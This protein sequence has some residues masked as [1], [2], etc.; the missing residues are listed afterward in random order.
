MHQLQGM[1]QMSL[2]S[3]I[4]DTKPATMAYVHHIAGGNELQR[5]EL[6]DKWQMTD[7][8]VEWKPTRSGKS[9]I[10]VPWG[11]VIRLEQN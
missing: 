7:L 2:P 10:L 9:V 8:G 11:R 6:L 3:W 1:G 5:T 4:D